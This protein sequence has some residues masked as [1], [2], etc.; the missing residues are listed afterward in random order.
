LIKLLSKETIDKIAAGEVVERPEN[1]VKELLDN[2]IDSGASAVSVEIRNGGIELIRVTDNGCGISREDLPNAFTRH[3]TSKLFTAEDLLHI[4]TMGFRG[5]ALASI[6]GVSRVELITRR[7]E[8]ITGSRYLI[9][10]GN[11]VSVRDI[12][13]PNG[14]SVIVRDLFFNVPVRRTFLKQPKTEGSYVRDIVEKSALSCPNISFSFLS[15]GK[16]MFHTS[17]NGKLQDVIYTIY[18]NDVISNMIP[19]QYEGIGGKVSGYISKPTLSRTRRDS[20]IYFVNG[21]FVRSNVIDRAIETAYEGYLMQHRFPFTVLSVEI[22][23]EYVDVNIHPKKTEVRF[24][25][26]E[27]V[28]DLIFEAVR[29]T[30]AHREHIQ[31]AL[32][33]QEPV[34]KEKE[35]HLEPFEEKKQKTETIHMR[36]ISE[37]TPEIS[38][39]KE[40]SKEIF[41]TDKRTECLGGPDTNNK[42]QFKSETQIT[43]QFKSETKITE[44]FKSETQKPEQLRFLDKEAKKYYKFIGQVFNTYWMI[45]Y[46]GDLYI[47]DQHAAHEKV[48]YER[49]TDKISRNEVTSQSIIPVLI[50][51]NAKDA[52]L[53]EQHLDDFSK[54]GYEIES[55]G[56]KDFYVRAVPA[57]LPELSEKEM[58]MNMIEGL[59]DSGQGLKNTLLAEKIASMSCKA[60]VKGNRIL[61]ETE[62]RALTDE[63]LLCRDPYNCPHGRPV[64]I[65]FSKYE[66]DKM[67]KRIV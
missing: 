39:L 2:A 67:F 41:K 34:Q 14:T 58:L 23:P 26:D 1:V 5:E 10:G 57:C 31:E 9:E 11:E 13:V 12:G 4:R 32:K 52:S 37:N 63:L 30:M 65:K 27:S 7:K 54:V 59:Q 60:A 18:G 53:L 22:A 29:D 43:G 21:R 51:L 40:T 17:G 25:E 56:D 20:E 64:M 8:D 49:L 33:K 28:F 6:A 42:E 38:I 24:S 36:H 15:D 3:A 35:I 16:Q 66:L 61:T 45:E 55:A 46:E 62:M 44:Q 19:V 50:T 48:N 47:I